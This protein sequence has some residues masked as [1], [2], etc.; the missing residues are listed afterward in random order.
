MGLTNRDIEDGYERNILCYDSDAKV[1][2]LTMRLPALMSTIA[3]RNGNVLLHTLYVGEEPVLDAFVDEDYTTLLAYGIEIVVDPRLSIGGEFTKY[4]EEL[5]GTIQSKDIHLVI[6]EGFEVPTD[7]GVRLV[8]S[9]GNRV[10]ILL[11]SC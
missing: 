4:F 9:N 11:G 7:D 8:R 6:G 1:G 5:G 2:E 3:R 10:H